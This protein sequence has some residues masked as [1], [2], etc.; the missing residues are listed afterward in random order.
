MTNSHIRKRI[1][2]WHFDESFRCESF[3]WS[4]GSRPN[5]GHT[6]N[7]KQISELVFLVAAILAIRDCHWIAAIRHTGSQRRLFGRFLFKYELLYI[8]G[9]RVSLVAWPDK[10]QTDK[11]TYK[12]GSLEVLF[13]NLTRSL[14]YFDPQNWICSIESSR[15]NS[16]NV[17]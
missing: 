12:R 4:F 11:L 7:E 17:S 8:V 1:N 6:Q 16:I 15:S 3:R 9:E 5:G 2:H 10:R 14:V 13:S